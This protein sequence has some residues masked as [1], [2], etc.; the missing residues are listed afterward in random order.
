[1]NWRIVGRFCRRVGCLGIGEGKWVEE[2]GEWNGKWRSRMWVSYSRGRERRA[3]YDT[4]DM[5]R[6]E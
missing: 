4:H 6:N 5:T 3:K 2:L 1:M